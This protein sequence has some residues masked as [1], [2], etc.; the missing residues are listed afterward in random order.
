[1]EIDEINYG[2]ESEFHMLR[3]FESPSVEL[4]QK[5]IDSGYSRIQMEAELNEP[6]SR[7][8]RSF[9]T[10]ILS[11]LH[12]I[13]F[14]GFS[15]QIGS[16]G[17]IILNGMVKSAD[18]SGGI[19]T[20]SVISIEDIE[21][22]NRSRIFFKKNRGID[23]LHLEVEILPTTIEF[24]II[25]RKTSNNYIFITAFPGEPSMPLPTYDMSNDLRKQCQDYWA[26]HVFLV[27][28]TSC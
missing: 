17:N 27:K 25:L 5:L 2:I 26:T 12:Q 8:W 3:H 20:K 19:G 22:Q 18:Y 6:G 15:T 9:A 28:S 13:F 24:T 4:T 10:D 11:L 7:F 1:M 23:L 21:D 16:N 14:N